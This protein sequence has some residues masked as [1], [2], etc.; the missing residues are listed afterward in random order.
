[1]GHSRK[2]MAA[3]LAGRYGD[4]SIRFSTV[5]QLVAI[6]GASY[7]TRVIVTDDDVF[8]DVLTGDMSPLVTVPRDQVVACE[9]EEWNAARHEYGW[10]LSTGFLHGGTRVAATS[11]VVLSLS[12]DAQILMRMPG[13]PVTVRHELSSVFPVGTPISA[14]VLP[15]GDAIDK[16]RRLATLRDEGI[17]TPAEFESKKAEL[18]NDI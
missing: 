4:S 9:V 17:L 13:P 5:P 16:L 12:N 7:S 1:M 11:G 3:L 10:R 18:L 14:A 2:E 15:E 6:A 8:F